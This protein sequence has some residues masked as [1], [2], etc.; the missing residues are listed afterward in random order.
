MPQ[1]QNFRARFFD[2]N[3]GKIHIRVISSQVVV[4]EII[5]IT[6]VEALAP[7]YP[8]AANHAQV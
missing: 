5:L 2:E 3:P 7:F 6:V 1:S 8:A 4:D